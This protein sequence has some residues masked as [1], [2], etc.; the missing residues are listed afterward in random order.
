MVDE[1]QSNKDVPDSA[2]SLADSRLDSTESTDKRHQDA[3]LRWLKEYELEDFDI[4]NT[5]EDLAMTTKG[6]SAAVADFLQQP[7]PPPP[8]PC[9]EVQTDL[10]T[11]YEMKT[12]TSVPI[13]LRSIFM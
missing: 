6:Y 2:E 1:V 10:T 8:P 9:I 4:V 12:Y 13:L 3:S 7:P 11:D 5:V